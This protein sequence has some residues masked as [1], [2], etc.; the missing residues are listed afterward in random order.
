[1][2][3]VNILNLSLSK[4]TSPKY[5][6]IFGIIYFVSI[7]TIYFIR[8]STSNIIGY[9]EAIYIMNSFGHSEYTP[10]TLNK[11]NLL[12]SIQT[13]LIRNGEAPG[14]FVLLYLWGLIYK[15]E[16]W[17]RL[18]PYLF[19]IASLLCMVK[20]FRN[21]NFKLYISLL[22]STILLLSATI[23]YHTL[24]L[25]SYGLEL[26]SNFLCYVTL[27]FLL[28]KNRLHSVNNWFIFFVV[29]LFGLSSRWSFLI[30]YCSI[31]L[32]LL[33]YLFYIKKNNLKIFIY[34]FTLNIFSILYFTFIFLLTFGANYGIDLGIFTQNKSLYIDI[35]DYIKYSHNLILHFLN[36][37]K[38]VIS[39]VFVPLTAIYFIH[40]ND[41]FIILNFSIIL[42]IINLYFLNCAYTK[43][44]IFFIFTIL[45]FSYVL[46]AF[47]SSFVE[48]IFIFS[49]F[50]LITIIICYGVSSNYKLSLKN[51]FNKFIKNIKALKLDQSI[52]LIL[53]I[54]TIIISVIF[55][56]LHIYPLDINS[57]V[58]LYLEAHFFVLLSYFINLL[59]R[60]YSQ[61]FKPKK[62]IISFVF[63]LLSLNGVV[64]SFSDH[65]YRSGGRQDIYNSILNVIEFQNFENL[66]YIYISPG[67]SNTFKYHYN[68]GS[69]SSINKSQNNIIIE[70]KL[71]HT[72]KQLVKLKENLKENDKL[73][74]IVGHSNDLEKYNVYIDEIFFDYGIKYGN[75]YISNAL[76][77][78]ST[79]YVKSYY[80]TK[81]RNE[82]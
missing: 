52:L 3:I 50:I 18:L 54:L 6:N 32:F 13:G 35:N 79:D 74:I 69:L 71:L 2:S 65:T 21:F 70:N 23:N 58:S 33:I 63:I 30:T 17:L 76:N 29:I 66:D 75:K 82:I 43:I 15:N 44:N 55:N 10:V 59:Y 31:Q 64:F 53:P 16:I 48:F 11:N 46:N 38:E 39:L 62:I 9:D 81:T 27:L 73:L 56:L 61:L 47:N 78:N 68:F 28:N 1:M 67:V 14:I 41:L 36:S 45:I 8:N 4:P 42:I 25:R 60:R 51:N 57:R 24:E 26:F 34:Y 7:L 77:E 37:F 49:S 20:I 40:K 5:F 80:I 72:K 22:L 19:F 12:N